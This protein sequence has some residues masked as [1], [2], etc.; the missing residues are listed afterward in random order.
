[1]IEKFIAA[2]S[3]NSWKKFQKTDSVQ[4]TDL[5]FVFTTQKSPKA[6]KVP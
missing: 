5:I 3:F 6:P 1:M 4:K 2:E